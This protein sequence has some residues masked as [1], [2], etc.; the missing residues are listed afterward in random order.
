MND[1]THLKAELRAVREELAHRELTTHVIT[2]TSLLSP[3]MDIEFARLTQLSD[4]QLKQHEKR[5]LRDLQ[6]I[7]LD[8]PNQLYRPTNNDGPAET[9]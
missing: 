7:E 5:L 3:P 2:N 1:K 6:D 4:E 8:N 9:K